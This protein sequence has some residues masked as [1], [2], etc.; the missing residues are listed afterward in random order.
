[1]GL[2]LRP[3]GTPLVLNRRLGPSQHDGLD[4]PMPAGALG[5]DPSV[6][7]SLAE[8]SAFLCYY[9]NRTLI[10]NRMLKVERTGQC[11]PI[12]PPE[13]AETGGTYRFVVIGAIPCCRTA[14]WPVGLPPPLGSEIIGT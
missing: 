4:P 5:N 1:L 11:G 12:Q 9:Y 3:F 13:M 14:E 7:P 10:G 6:C 2:G 8:N